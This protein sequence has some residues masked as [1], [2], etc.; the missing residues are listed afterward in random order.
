M[1]VNSTPTLFNPILDLFAFLRRPDAV[2]VSA[3]LKQKL[4]AMAIIVALDILV[5]ILLTLVTAPIESLLSVQAQP[6]EEAAQAGFL[7]A[8]G[9]F[10]LRPLSK[11]CHSGSGLPRICSSSLSRLP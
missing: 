3:P 6:V 1:N 11:R 4:L 2:R 9:E 8:G 5:G 10:S 7:L